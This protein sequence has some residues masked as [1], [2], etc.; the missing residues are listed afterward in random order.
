MPSW[1][2]A[3]THSGPSPTI[4]RFPASYPSLSHFSVLAISS[5][6]QPLSSVTYERLSPSL[7]TPRHFVSWPQFSATILFPK[8]QRDCRRNLSTKTSAAVTFFGTTLK[9]TDDHR[10]Y[11]PSSRTICDCGLSTI[12]SYT[13]RSTAHRPATQAHQHSFKTSFG[14]TILVSTVRGRTH[15]LLWRVRLYSYDFKFFETF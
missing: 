14:Q 9:R 4:R 11:V 15:L 3:T 5:R 2:L 1:R 13:H 7:T 6:T 10:L 8:S 12:V